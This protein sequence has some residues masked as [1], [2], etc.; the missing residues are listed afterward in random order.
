MVV[1]RGR[2]GDL[3]GLPARMTPILRPGLAMAGCCEHSCGINSV[4]RAD[5]G[6]L[7]LEKAENVAL[8]V[9]TSGGSRA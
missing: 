5:S 9:A 6:K 7:M 8:I 2:D 4:C 3:V 1:Q